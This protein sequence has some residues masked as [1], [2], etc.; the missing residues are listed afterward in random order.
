MMHTASFELIFQK[1]QKLTAAVMFDFS[2]DG[3]TA[4]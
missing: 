2:F 1:Q 4:W 3:A